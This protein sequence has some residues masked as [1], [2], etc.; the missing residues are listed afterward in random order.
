MKKYL[1]EKLVDV[2]R[3]RKYFHTLPSDIQDEVYARI[4]ELI[5]EEE[6]YCDK[7]NYKHMAQILTAIALYEILQKHGKTEPEA[8]SIVSE[9][10]WKSLDPSPMQRL[11]KK[12]YFMPLMK[13]V[14]PAGFNSGSGY[15]WKYTWHK[16]GPKN[17]FRFE[18]NECIYEKI[19]GKRGLIKLGAMFCR[20]D[21]INYSELPYTDFIRTNT[22]CQG[23]SC[24]DFLFVRHET[25]A[26][27][28]WER[29]ASI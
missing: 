3:Y 6:K 14:V 15:G 22:L 19:L 23:G 21:I 9:E 8:F 5:I 24:C 16:G 27:C 4:R 28:G 13:L 2:C 7:G 10:M 1:P 18:T 17:E 25:D 26:G 29:H 11:A 12:R 20:A